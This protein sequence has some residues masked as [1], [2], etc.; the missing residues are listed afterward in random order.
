M[1]YQKSLKTNHKNAKK[2]SCLRWDLN[3]WLEEAKKLM[4]FVWNLY[5]SLEEKNFDSQRWQVTGDRSTC[6]R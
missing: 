3:S 6:D 5:T 2:E 4:N 1:L